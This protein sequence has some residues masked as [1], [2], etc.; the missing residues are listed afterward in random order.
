MRSQ[1][2][3]GR[4]ANRAL[5][6]GMAVSATVLAG[7][8]PALARLETW[9]E[10]SA[11]AFGKGRRDRVVIADNGRVRLGQTLKPLG[12]LDAARVWDL[13]RGANDT[14]FAAT[15]DDGKVF[16]R[17]PK[18]D[19]PWT[20][21]YDSTDTQALSLAVGPDGHVFAGT[22]PSG[23]VVDVTDPKHPASRPH[24][25]VQYIWDLAGD[26]KGNLFAATG[27]TGQLWKRSPD[28]AWS[29]LLDSKHPHLLCVAVA[30][31]G[32]L[33]AGSDGEGLVYKVAPG[34]KVSVLYDAPQSEVRTLLVG[35]DG[36]VYA[37]TAAEAGGGPGR[38]PSMFSGGGLTKNSG[39]P[40]GRPSDTL[41]ASARP[42]PAQDAPPTKPDTAPDQIRPRGPAPPGGGSASPRPASPGDNAVYRIDR[43]GV[44][45][46]LFRAKALVFA[47]ALQKDRVL[48]GT[49]PDG[50]LHELRD[51]GRESAPIARLD[52]GQILALLNEPGGGLLIGAGDPGS[53]VR[54]EPGHVSSG[55]LL[56]DVRDTKLISRFGA[57][58]WRAELPTGTSVALQVRTGNVSEPDATWSDWSPE[59]S[60]PDNAQAQ[61]PAGRFVQYRAKLST[62][63]P[64]VTPELHSVS[65]R[66]QSANLAPEINK[67]DVPD[68]SALDGAT[69]QT[70]LTFRWD[71]HDPNDDELEYTL[72]LRKE[73]WAGWVKLNEQPQTEKSFAW[74]TTSVPPGLYKVRLTA[75]D[76]PSN[77]ADDALS[78]EKVSETFIVDHEPPSVTIK[79][80]SRRAVATLKDKLTR[81]TK[82][83]Y[84]VDG[85]DWIPVFPE[86]G[87]FDT[88]SET[89][90]IP[91]PNLKPG[92]HVLV[93][94]ATDSAGNVGTGDALIEVR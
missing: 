9:R 38:S 36:A 59:Q 70:R 73:G 94:R 19:D 2:P 61:A 76:R 12:S 51:D 68:V 58:S 55:L 42:R 46:E 27:P 25:G 90:T 18:D 20:V 63:D 66:Y 72:H 41:T 3:E 69:R 92:T 57:I 14:L 86:D 88:P 75:S 10:E 71:V 47:L 62:R 29:L 31:D 4:A 67:L 22:G 5:V 39:S 82:S 45:R 60:D 56:S 1:P 24:P 26:E 13:A 78:R 17:G 37:G 28:G 65:L 54:L 85:G 52:S 53:V 30:G 7:W 44:A 64:S 15:G 87:L 23:Q 40:T 93:V 16:R 83:A 43:D 21:A 80:L 74:D 77:N 79:A 32:S 33:Y 84:A 34:G 91:L 81:I 11:S 50:Q 8:L 49:G 6:L 48:V 89:V 35:P